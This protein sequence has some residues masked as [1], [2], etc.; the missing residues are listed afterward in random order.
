MKIWI[1]IGITKGL[2]E[3][4]TIMGGNIIIIPS[5]IYFNYVLESHVVECPMVSLRQKILEVNLSAFIY[6]LFHEDFSDNYR[7]KH[8]NTLKCDHDATTIVSNDKSDF[9]IINFCL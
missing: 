5:H 7:N 9:F 1:A 8:S 2:L 6:R 3:G 4:S